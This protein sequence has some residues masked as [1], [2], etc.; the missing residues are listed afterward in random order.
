MWELGDTII[1][2]TRPTTCACRI[3]TEF[4][5]SVSII[6][7]TFEQKKVIGLQDIFVTGCTDGGSLILY[8]EK[9][10]IVDRRINNGRT[11]DKLFDGSGYTFHGFVG[12]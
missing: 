3:I 11:Y 5:V 7:K 6:P 12:I 4:C 9:Y 2:V 10:E 1:A 8:E